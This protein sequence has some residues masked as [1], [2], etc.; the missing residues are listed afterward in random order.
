MSKAQERTAGQVA[1][2]TGASYGIGAASAV[3]LADDG[4]DIIATATRIEN[5]ASTQAAVESRGVRFKPLAFDLRAQSSIDALWAD[6][7][8]ASG[9]VDVLV[10]NAAVTKRAP[11]V[12]IT[13][14]L[15][16]TVVHTNI[17]GT[18]FMC[19]QMGRHLIKSGRPGCII[20]LAST[21]GVVGVAERCPYGTAKAAIIHLTRILAIEWAP[22]GIRV[23]CVAPARVNTESPIRQATLADPKVKAARLARIPLHRFAEVEEVAG[24]VRYLASPDAA[25]V[26]GQTL[27]LDGGLTSQ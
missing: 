13:R 19:Q 16:E 2:V 10:N 26:T 4:Y 18:F 6:A 5:L 22:H 9:R 21:H 17:D 27:I 23:N 7:L 11:V 15:W 24:A 1:L 3:A 20:N 25:C 14:E 8:S 12:D